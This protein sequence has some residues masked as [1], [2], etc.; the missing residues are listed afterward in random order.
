MQFF[1]PKISPS[2]DLIDEFIP[3]L[4]GDVPSFEGRFDLVSVFFLLLSRSLANDKCEVRGMADGTNILF[5]PLVEWQRDVR[6]GESV[7]VGFTD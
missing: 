7:E 5:P 1:Q 2:I 3:L 6:D 4:L